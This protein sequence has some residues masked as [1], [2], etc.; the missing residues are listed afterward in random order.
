MRKKFTVILL[1]AALAV[2][3]LPACGNVGNTDGLPDDGETRSLYGN[4]LI[5]QAYGN[6]EKVS[7]AVSHSFVELYNVTEHDISL[8]GASLQY[9]DSKTS[10]WKRMPL[11]G[12]VNAYSS[13]FIRGTAASDPENS[14]LIFSE[15]EADMNAEFT[16]DNDGFSVCLLQSKALLSVDNPFDIDG[17]GTK[18]EGYADMFG[19]SNSGGAV[20]NG[21]E[22][23]ECSDNII[24]KQKAARRKNL[25]DTDDNAF[26]FKTVDYRASGTTADELA[27]Y[28]PK[29][30]DYGA[31]DP[32]TF[33]LTATA[34]NTN[35]PP[36]DNTPPA[37]V[38]G[39]VML[40]QAA[41]TFTGDNISVSSSEI[42]GTIVEISASGTYVLRGTLTK[43]FVAV[44][45][46]QLA[47]TLV[48]DGADISCANYAPIV[49]T[50]KSD[51]TIELAENSKNYLTDGASYSYGYD[52]DH[53]PNAAL[54]IRKDM[55]ISGSGELTVNGK[56]NNGIGTKAH[57]E[58]VGG[59]I[60]VSAVNN[61][62]KGNDSIK[63]S[64][65][66]FTLSSQ[67]DG[68]KSDNTD[69]AGLGYIDITGGV[70]Q[71]TTVNDAVQSSTSLKIANAD[72]TMKTGGGSGAAATAGSAK[73]LKAETTLT[74]QSGTFNID[75]ND[76]GIH[77]NGD[78]I[79]DGG[80]VNISSG[81]DGIHADGSLTI[82]GGYINISKS[83]EG[84][85]ALNV[86]LSGGEVRIVASDDGINISGG[87]DNSANNRPTPGR[88]GGGW[89]QPGGVI[90]GKLTITG[91]RYYIN[92]AGD[93]LDS[94][95]NIVM[96]G[97]LVVVQG[98]TASM[99][100]PI[101]FDGTF[102]MTGGTIIALG[103]AGMAQQPSSSSTQYSVLIKFSSVQ[104]AG[105]LINLRNTTT[106][107]DIVTI[108]C[109]KQAGSLAVC[110]P[111]LAR[112][113]YTVSAGGSYSPNT[114]DG[115]GLYSGGTYSGGTTLRTFTISNIIT[116]A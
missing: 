51:V 66:S 42:Y 67:S 96:S 38:T 89:T 44:S 92:A 39:T 20:V 27:K 22:G 12:T 30:T 59:D 84:L 76:D 34:D 80:T 104:A 6:G 37:D 100:A 88:P 54:Y 85:E 18:A 113:S 83:Y 19:S 46:T 71:I 21:Y 75:S 111:E 26:D 72:M 50:K 8:E 61:A 77:C 35:T 16:L 103:S 52:V 87:A 13:F 108:A 48:L 43:G 41:T 116:T 32:I 40:S 68:I 105:R 69:E 2:M 93:G 94:N 29:N 4:I 28:R 74:V 65:G 70:F 106:G 24:S 79:I 1:A 49:C 14:R 110:S 47:V 31:W 10:A 63:I 23:A 33:N 115:F 64:G 5:L 36:V 53:E 62:L 15:T 45:K 58:V 60:A 17:S 9:S 56:N 114:P 82:N 57:L 73:G 107:A 7:S 90:D 78:I 101:D 112:G 97:G 98:P 91:G 99:D 25:T 86:N 11:S 81:D 55:K 102:T 3:M 109:L 95:G